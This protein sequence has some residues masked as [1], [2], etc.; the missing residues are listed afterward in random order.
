M[1]LSLPM[2]LLLTLTVST[3]QQATNTNAPAIVPFVGE[4]VVVV[5]HLDLTRWDDQ[6]SFR[7]VLGKLANGDELHAGARSIE[8]SIDALKAAGAKD[9]FL[10]FEPADMSGLPTAV[11]PLVDGADGKLIVSVLS[12]GMPRNSYRWP[13]SETIRGAVV[14]G[15]PVCLNRIRDAMPSPRPELLAALAA[16]GNSL[17]QM[18]IVPSTTLRRSIEESMAVL[19]RELGGGSITTITQGVRWISFTS[20]SEPGPV[21]QALVQARDA[22]ASRALLELAQDGLDSLAKASQHEPA[23]A[24]LTS[25]ITRMKPVARGDRITIEAGLEQTAELVFVPIRQA[26]EAARRSQCTNNLKQIGLAVPGYH[27]AH[28]TFPPAFSKSPDGKPL[29]S[30]RVLILPY[31]GQKALYDEFRLD[32]PWDSE[33]N[34]TLISRMPA[35]Y[36]CPSGSPT[37]AKD[38]KTSYLTPRGPATM[39]PGAHA[40]R[41]S[42]ILDGTSNTLFVVDA[43]DAAAVTWTQPDDWDNSRDIKAQGLF[44]HHAEGTNVVFADGSVD[45]LKEPISPRVLRA[46]TTCNGGEYIDRNDL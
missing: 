3:A 28:G 7:R 23:L 39:F 33:H 9:M 13:A 40:L 44:G 36:T 17:I 46:L 5:V 45:F 14:A 25:T 41:I 26:R 11:V 12:H 38:G 18:A 2:A 16:G 24:S 1:L 19:P 42:D 8:T 43:N 34:K 10:L 4:E 20:V 35:V 30:W 6:N 29:L 15:T 37:L 32:E 21:V 31:L 27:R 22:D